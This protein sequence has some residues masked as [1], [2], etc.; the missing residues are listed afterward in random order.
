MAGT[1]SS[2]PV[3]FVL[4]IGLILAW[5]VAGYLGADYFLL[6]FLGTLW[7]GETAASAGAVLATPAPVVR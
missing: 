4:A 3:L 6:R 1:A 2:N 7:R 5:K